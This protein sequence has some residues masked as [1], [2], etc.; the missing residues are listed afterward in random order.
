M[1]L[2][3][4]RNNDQ[5]NEV[6]GSRFSELE[7]TFHSIM[8]DVP[9]DIETM[10]TAFTFCFEMY[11]LLLLPIPERG[12]HRSI[13]LIVVVSQAGSLSSVDPKRVE[14]CLKQIS[15]TYEVVKNNLTKENAPPHIS[16]LLSLIQLCGELNDP[17]AAKLEIKVVRYLQRHTDAESGF[18]LLVVPET[19]MLF[20]QAV[21]DTVLQEE[22]RFAGPSSCFAKALE[23]KQPITLADIPVERRHEVEKIIRRQINTLLCVPVCVSDSKD[24]L[25]LA[26]MV[27]KSNNEQFTQQ[28]IDTILQCFKYTATVLTSTLAFQNERKLKNQTQ[29]LLLVARKLFTR[30]D[31]NL[32][33]SWNETANLNKVSS[34]EPDSG[35]SAGLSGSPRL[36]RCQGLGPTSGH[37]SEPGCIAQLINSLPTTQAQ[38][39][40][41]VLPLSAFRGSDQSSSVCRPES[42][43]VERA[44]ST[45]RH[46]RSD[47]ESSSEYSTASSSAPSSNQPLLNNDPNKKP[48]LDMKSDKSTDPTFCGEHNVSDHRSIADSSTCFYFKQKDDLAPDV[49]L[50]L[51]DQHEDMTMKELEFNRYFFN[52]LEQFKELLSAVDS[53]N[54]KYASPEFHVSPVLNTSPLANVSSMTSMSPDIMKDYFHCEDNVHLPDKQIHKID[55]Y[56]QCESCKLKPD[57]RSRTFRKFKSPDQTFFGQKQGVKSAL[58]SKRSNSISLQSCNIKMLSHTSLPPEKGSHC[59]T[60]IKNTL[61]KQCRSLSNNRNMVNRSSPKVDAGYCNKNRKPVCRL[62]RSVSNS[63]SRGVSLSPMERKKTSTVVEVSTDSVYQVVKPSAQCGIEDVS[64]EASFHSLSDEDTDLDNT[65]TSIQRLLTSIQD[66]SRNDLQCS[67]VLKVKKCSTEEKSDLFQ[68]DSDLGLQN[69]NDK[70][71]AEVQVGEKDEDSVC[72]LGVGKSCHSNEQGFAL[73]AENF[74]TDELVT[75]PDPCRTTQSSPLNQQ[76]S[77]A[78]L[79]GERDDE[80]VTYPDP[81]RTTHSS[82]L[83]VQAS[84]AQLTG[85]GDHLTSAVDRH[86]ELCTFGLAFGDSF[87]PVG[88][89]GKD[90]VLPVSSKQDSSEQ[91]LKVEDIVVV[92]NEETQFIQGSNNNDNNCDYFQDAFDCF[93][94]TKMDYSHCMKYIETDHF[95]SDLIA[96]EHVES[97]HVVSVARNTDEEVSIKIHLEDD[98]RAL[99]FHNNEFISDGELDYKDQSKSGEDANCVAGINAENFTCAS[100]VLESETNVKTHHWAYHLEQGVDS[101]APRDVIPSAIDLKHLSS[102][103]EPQFVE[104][105]SILWEGSLLSQ[106]DE[107]SMSV[108]GDVKDL[109]S[110]NGSEASNL[111]LDLDMCSVYLEETNYED[112][113]SSHVIRVPGDLQQTESIVTSSI[114]TDA[115][116][117]N[118][119]ISEYKKRFLEDNISLPSVET[120]CR[121]ELAFKKSDATTEIECDPSLKTETEENKDLSLRSHFLNINT[122]NVST[123]K[124]TDIRAEKPIKSGVIWS[125]EI[126]SEVEHCLVPD[127][128][129]MFNMNSDLTLHQDLSVKQTTGCIFDQECPNV[130]ANVVNLDSLDNIAVDDDFI[131]YPDMCSYEIHLKE[132]SD[133]LSSDM[134]LKEDSRNVHI[135]VASQDYSQQEESDQQVNEESDEQINEES[136]QEV[137]EK[138]DQQINEESHQQV[139][140]E[141]DQEVNE[142][143]FDQQVYKES[144][145]EVNEESDQEVNESYQNV[146]EESDQQVNEESDQQINEES[147]QEV[148]EE[149][150]DQQVNEK[151]DQEVNESYQNVN[152]E[153]DQEVNEKSDQQINEESHQQVNGESDQEVNEE[154][155]QEVNEESDQEVK[156]ESNQQINEEYDQQV[157]DER[158]FNKE[159]DQE[160]NEEFDQQVKEESDQEVNE[161]FVQEINEESDQEVNEESDQEVNEESDQQVNE[162]SDQEVN[163]ESDQQVNEE[164]NQEVNEKSDQQINEEFHQQVNGESDQEVNEESN[165]EVNEESDQ[166]VKEESDQQINEEYD[167]QINDEREFNKESDQEVNEEFDQEINEESDQD[168]NEE[169]DQEVNEES[170]QEVNEESDQE[171]NEESDQEVNEESDQQVNEESDQQ[172]NEE[173]DPQVIK[174]S[175]QQDNKESDQEINDE[176]D[177]KEELVQ[178]VKDEIEIKEE[179]VQEVNDEIEIN[180]VFDHECYDFSEEFKKINDESDQDVNDEIDFKDE[181]CQFNDEIDFNE[182][183]GQQVNDEIEFSEESDQKVNEEFDQEVTYETDF[184]KE[185]DQQL[186]NER[187]FK[188]H[189]HEK[190]LNIESNQEV[191]TKLDVQHECSLQIIFTTDFS[192]KLNLET[193]G[194]ICSLKKSNQQNVVAINTMRIT[195]QIK[196]NEESNQILDEINVKK[197]SSQILDDI[198]FNADSIQIQSK[199]DFNAELSQIQKESSQQIHNVKDFEDESNH[200]IQ[201]VKLSQQIHDEIDF[202]EIFVQYIHDEI[203]FNKEPG[204]QSHDDF[205]EEAGQQSQDD[206]NEEAGQQSQ[207]DFNE[208]PGQQ[209]H[210][211]FNEEPGQQSHDDFNEEPGQQSHDDFNEEPAQ[212]S[213]DDF[214]EEPGQQ[215]QDDFNEEAGQQSH[216]DFNEEPSQQSHDDFN[217]EAAQ[218]IHDDDLSLKIQEEKDICM[219]LSEQIYY[220]EDYIA[221]SGQQSHDETDLKEE[222]RP[223]NQNKINLFQKLNPQIIN[224]IASCD[225]LN[226]P[227]NDEID[228]TSESTQHKSYESGITQKYVESLSEDQQIITALNS[229]EESRE[230]MCPDLDW[231]QQCT[232]SSDTLT[233]IQETIEQVTTEVNVHSQTIPSLPNKTNALFIQDT[234]GIIKEFGLIKLRQPMEEKTT[235]GEEHHLITAMNF[236]N[237][238]LNEEHNKCNDTNDITADNQQNILYKIELKKMNEQVLEEDICTEIS[239]RDILKVSCDETSSHYTDEVFI[240]AFSQLI[241]DEIVEVSSQQSDHDVS[242]QQSDNEIDPED[243]IISSLGQ[244][245]G[246]LINILHLEPLSDQMGVCEYD[247]DVVCLDSTQCLPTDLEIKYDEGSISFLLETADELE[248]TELLSYPTR[249]QDTTFH[250]EMGGQMYE[251]EEEKLYQLAQEILGESPEQEEILLEKTADLNYCCLDYANQEPVVRRQDVYLTKDLFLTDSS[252]EVIFHTDPAIETKCGSSFDQAN[253]HLK[254]ADISNRESDLHCEAHLL[255]EHYVKLAHCATCYHLT[256]TDKE[257]FEPFETSTTDSSID[258]VTGL[259]HVSLGTIADA[260]SPKRPLT[261]SYSDH[262]IAIG[263]FNSQSFPLLDD[264]SMSLPDISICSHFDWSQNSNRPMTRF[265]DATDMRSWSSVPSVH[266]KMSPFDS[267]LRKTKSDQNLKLWSPRYSWSPSTQNSFYVHP[268]PWH[269]HQ[270]ANDLSPLCISSSGTLNTSSSSLGQNI[271]ATAQRILKEDEEIRSDSSTK[272]NIAAGYS[273]HLKD[274][275]TYGEFSRDLSHLKSKY[276]S[277]FKSMPRNDMEDLSLKT[278]SNTKRIVKAIRNNLHSSYAR[279]SDILKTLY[280]PET[281]SFQDPNSQPDFK[282]NWKSSGDNER[283]AFR[284]HSKK[285]TDDFSEL[286][287]VYTRNNLEHGQGFNEHSGQPVGFSSQSCLVGQESELMSTSRKRYISDYSHRTWNESDLN[288][289]AD[290]TDFLD[291]KKP[292]PFDHT[293]YY[294]NK[295]HG[296]NTYMTFSCPKDETYGRLIFHQHNHGDESQIPSHSHFQ[297]SFMDYLNADSRQHCVSFLNEKTNFD[298]STESGLDSSMTDSLFDGTLDKGSDDSYE[299]H[300]LSS[301]FAGARGKENNNHYDE[302]IL[303]SSLAEEV[304]SRDDMEDTFNECM[305]MNNKEMED[306]GFVTPAFTNRGINAILAEDTSEGSDSGESDPMENNVYPDTDAPNVCLRKTLAKQTGQKDVK[307]SDVQRG[308]V[309]REN[310]D[311]LTLGHLD[312]NLAGGP[313]NLNINVVLQN[314]IGNSED[315]DNI[316]IEGL[317]S[318]LQDYQSRGPML[319]PVLEVLDDDPASRTDELNSDCSPGEDTQVSEHVHENCVLKEDKMED[320]PDISKYK[321]QNESSEENSED[322]ITLETDKITKVVYKSKTEELKKEGLGDGIAHMSVGPKSL[323]LSDA[324]EDV[325]VSAGDNAAVSRLV[326]ALKQL[327]SSALQ[328]I[329]PD[330]SKPDHQFVSLMNKEMLQMFTLHDTP[331]NSPPSGRSYLND[332]K[333]HNESCSS[334]DTLSLR[335][336]LAEDQQEKYVHTCASQSLLNKSEFQGDQNQIPEIINSDKRTTLVTGVLKPLNCSYNLVNDSTHDTFISQTPL[337]PR[338]YRDTIINRSVSTDV[339]GNGSLGSNLFTNSSK[340]LDI[341]SEGMRREGTSFFSKI[342]GDYSRDTQQQNA[343]TKGI[344]TQEALRSDK[345]LTSDS[346]AQDVPVDNFDVID[347]SLKPRISCPQLISKDSQKSL[348]CHFSD[349]NVQKLK[350]QDELVISRPQNLLTSVSQNREDNFPILNSVWPKL[351]KTQSLQSNNY[352]L[353]SFTMNSPNRSTEL[354]Y[355]RDLGSRCRSHGALP[356]ISEA[357]EIFNSNSLT[358]KDFIMEHQ[359]SDIDSS[360]THGAFPQEMSLCNT[361]TPYNASQQIHNSIIG[362]KDACSGQKDE[363]SISFQEFQAKTFN[364]QPFGLVNAITSKHACTSANISDTTREIHTQSDVDTILNAVTKEKT[365]SNDDVF[366]KVEEET[367]HEKSGKESTGQLG[368]NGDNNQIRR[369]VTIQERHVFEKLKV[370]STS[371]SDIKIVRDLEDDKEARLTKQIWKAADVSGDVGDR[372]F[373]DQSKREN[374]MWASRDQS[375]ALINGHGVYKI[376][377]SNGDGCIKSDDCHAIKSVVPLTYDIDHMKTLK[378]DSHGR[379]EY[380]ETSSLPIA[381][382]V[383]ADETVTMENKAVGSSVQTQEKCVETDNCI[384]NEQWSNA[385]MDPLFKSPYLESTTLN[386]KQNDLLK[387]FCKTDVCLKEIKLVLLNKDMV[388]AQV[389]SNGKTDQS[390]LGLKHLT[391]KLSSVPIIVTKDDVNLNEENIELQKNRFKSPIPNSS[392]FSVQ[393]NK[394]L[395]PVQD[396]HTKELFA[397]LEADEQSFKSVCEMIGNKRD[398]SNDTKQIQDPHHS[399]ALED[400]Q[401]STPLMDKLASPLLVDFLSCSSE[402]CD[403]EWQSTFSQSG[404][405]K[406]YDTFPKVISFDH[407]KSSS[408]SSFPDITDFDESNL[409]SDEDTRDADVSSLDTT[410]IAPSYS[411]KY[412]LSQPIKYQSLFRKRHGSNQTKSDLLFHKDNPEVSLFAPNLNLVQEEII[413]NQKDNVDSCA[414]DV[415][416]LSDFA[417][418]AAPI[419]CFPTIPFSVAPIT[420]RFPSFFKTQSCQDKKNTTEKQSVFKQRGCQQER[421]NS[422]I[423]ADKSGKHKARASDLAGQLYSPRVSPKKHLITEGEATPGSVLLDS[424]Y[425]KPVQ[426]NHWLAFKSPPSFRPSPT[427]KFKTKAKVHED[428]KFHRRKKL[429][430][431]LESVAEEKRLFPLPSFYKEINNANS[432]DLIFDWHQEL[433]HNDQIEDV[434]GFDRTVQVQDSCETC[435]YNSPE[436]I[437]V[438]SNQSKRSVSFQLPSEYS[439]CIIDTNYTS[440][441]QVTSVDQDLD[442]KPNVT[443]VEIDYEPFLFRYRKPGLPVITEEVEDAE[444]DL[445]SDSSPDIS[446]TSTSSSEAFTEEAQKEETCT[447]TRKEICTTKCSQEEETRDQHRRHAR[448]FPEL[449]FFNSRSSEEEATV[450]SKAEV[451]DLVARNSDRKLPDLSFFA[452]QTCSNGDFL[453]SNCLNSDHVLCQMNVSDTE[454]HL[455]INVEFTSDSINSEES[456]DQMTVSLQQD[457]GSVDT[458]NV[459]TTTESNDK[460]LDISKE[461]ILSELGPGKEDFSQVKLCTENSISNNRTS[462]ESKEYA[463]PLQCLIDKT[464]A[465]DNKECHVSHKYNLPL[466]NIKTDE[467]FVDS[468]DDAATLLRHLKEMDLTLETDS[469]LSFT[470][471]FDSPTKSTYHIDV[472]CVVHVEDC[473]SEASSSS[474]LI[475][476]SGHEI[477]ISAEWKTDSEEPSETDNAIVKNIVSPLGADDLNQAFNAGT[478]SDQKDD[479]IDSQ[480]NITYV[481]DESNESPESTSHKNDAC[482]DLEDDMNASSEAY[483]DNMERLGSSDEHLGDDSGDSPSDSDILLHTSSI[484]KDPMVLKRLTS[485]PPV[486]QKPA[487]EDRS[488]YSLQDSSLVVPTLSSDSFSTYCSHQSHL[489]DELELAAFLS[490]DCAESQDNKRCHLDCSDIA[491]DDRLVS[492][493]SVRKEE[494][495][496][497]LT[498]ESDGIVNKSSNSEDADPEEEKLEEGF[499]IHSEGLDSTESLTQWTDQ[500]SPH[501][502][503]LCY[504]H[505]YFDQTGA[506]ADTSNENSILDVHVSETSG[507][508]VEKLS[509]DGLCQMEILHHVSEPLDPNVLDT[510]DSKVEDENAMV[511]SSKLQSENLCDFNINLAPRSLVSHSL[512]DQT[513]ESSSQSGL[514][515]QS[516][517]CQLDDLF[518]ISSLSDPDMTVTEE[519]HH[520]GPDTCNLSFSFSN[521]MF[522][523]CQGGEKKRYSSF[524]SLSP[525]PCLR[526]SKSDHSVDSKSLCQNWIL[527]NNSFHDTQHLMFPEDKRT[528]GRNTVSDI[529]DFRRSAHKGPEYQYEEMTSFSAGW[530]SNCLLVGE[531]KSGDKVEDLNQCVLFEEDSKVMVTQESGTTEDISCSCHPV[532]SKFS[533]A[534]LVQHLMA[535]DQLENFGFCDDD[536]TKLLRE[537]MQEARNLTDAERCSVFLLDKDTDELV[538]MVFD[539]ITADDKEWQYGDG[540]QGEIRLPKTQGIAGHVATTGTLL[541]IRDAYSHP[542]FYRGIDDST[543]FRTRN[544]L[545]FP[546]KDEEG[547]VLGV[548]QLCNKKT[549][550]YFTTFDED[551]ASAFAVYCCISISHSLMY[552]KVIDI[553]YRNSLANELMMFH[554][555]SLMYKKLVDI[556]HRH[557]LANELMI[558]HI[559]QQVPM[560]EVQMMAENPI[561]PVTTFSINFDSFDFAPRTIPES[562]TV[563]SCI[564]MFEDLGFLAR[565]RIKI[566]TLVRFLLMVKKGYR[567]PPYHN[568][569]HAYAVTHFCYLL[570]KNLHLHNYLD[571][572]ELLALFVSCLCHDIDHRGTTNSFQ[573]QSQSVLAAL[574]SSEGSVMERH[575]LAQSMCILNTD[576]SNLFENLSS[577]EYQT[578]LDLM[579]EIILA[580]DLAHHLRTVKEQEQLAE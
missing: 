476:S 166:E 464:S 79:T 391:Q 149:F 28:D 267:Q 346:R 274:S 308:Y 12:T 529:S 146:N 378:S 419:K 347:K 113:A 256:D 524:I 447:R 271:S 436:A 461:A 205:N 200:Y 24:L 445:N 499:L 62:C 350:Q 366:V 143:F 382:L 103:S 489:V 336:S 61:S 1:N 148:N 132:D 338:G 20:C 99:R 453:E 100:R 258:E 360:R 444:T 507:L 577:K 145:Q 9:S 214:N 52:N 246:P 472:S 239:Y 294:K 156:E 87:E 576:G 410:L 406:F 13:G 25:A 478:T 575:H 44:H 565:W 539:G 373:F 392:Y 567:N 229:N 485:E 302:T 399:S 192:Q 403:S 179:L 423:L 481:L 484:I 101:S 15:V 85:E 96:C 386:I 509:Q 76:A 532:S 535:R 124:Q 121:A 430:S 351:N 226:F 5:S 168:V 198:N 324:K 325:C 203:G 74:T 300:F 517:L 345:H 511:D 170:D 330:G 235:E 363:L 508:G 58:Q 95:Q 414:A 2:E 134:S 370:T 456:R 105:L 425:S 215:S 341:L 177:I 448:Y 91:I 328:S 546:I 311:P 321:P 193:N 342:R 216:D 264:Q 353:N 494:D 4:C 337:S 462:H 521:P 238:E 18:L 482:D 420:D 309:D 384:T 488:V 131:F 75:Y 8:L 393:H 122:D 407:S 318:A 544:I 550:Q 278:E 147:D 213:H 441:S 144:D 53:D 49:G 269:E 125:Q 22:V 251:I 323:Q 16:N 40:L 362:S 331:V 312:C 503:R 398:S 501:G 51:R 396:Q 282:S 263:F 506:E 332:D 580:T 257:H 549:F 272:G 292:L 284:Y 50:R 93:Q 164:S 14:L 354:C 90:P 188:P 279:S 275:F 496:T 140:G 475:L 207:D 449:P 114:K 68:L 515:G 189:H 173:T 375:N 400:Q 574:Y 454:I 59:S 424:F 231:N 240:E 98:Q 212:Q 348:Y 277:G 434:A 545:C 306:H 169:S 500:V 223:K 232:P 380:T 435:E 29:A 415:E 167:Q 265:S 408:E 104:E 457:L 466:A 249:V 401:I 411:E 82:P 190:D 136:N 322:F 155:N 562:Q 110:L 372:V 97:S 89:L 268:K 473:D 191:E 359:V 182:D 480:L 572:I 112:V 442:L 433:A 530:S 55:N 219:K 130:S 537:I 67:L 548:A 513:S 568:W 543:G 236:N 243:I 118:S 7:S 138:S 486:K 365:T 54:V 349:G 39:T 128:I 522:C 261:I 335:R 560:E 527:Q 117:I 86:I 254:W 217:E 389:D 209:S 199:V 129:Q 60:R 283:G 151:S 528:G 26:C 266:K 73:L 165:Q 295:I 233:L 429:F 135:S 94:E 174:E 491:E 245:N 355:Q 387:L 218:P 467:T 559:N 471:Q 296:S 417:K 358:K 438:E 259:K 119:L 66:S 357:Y 181:V 376:G 316:N 30:L 293:K 519:L 250:Y 247:N 47:S 70:S 120:H 202:K 197:E 432:N 298:L 526:K 34:V 409:S 63:R 186:V 107:E 80:L 253:S 183:F 260:L 536:L 287:H 241:H 361:H 127:N 452:Q 426:A 270:Q 379:P 523:H 141:S 571:D 208:E 77:V 404:D 137:N 211:D 314:S 109:E 48:S 175:D 487:K 339:M 552:K 329:P 315:L 413:G 313:L 71:V 397:E 172:V 356:R 469:D 304:S 42:C 566:D 142:E 416:S 505:L 78:Q 83:T 334:E 273:R 290:D 21:G 502:S 402:S 171:V 180:K 555:K 569:M 162:E 150:F 38:N 561:L 570:I 579:R 556:Q 299:C 381:D 307:E 32:S 474:S 11:L 547:M 333:P 352:D 459:N 276:Q 288:L 27:N 153:S 285:I 463:Q 427:N 390:S 31:A 317:Q 210:D 102:G 65:D 319:S 187:E 184:N 458:N 504:Y 126:N 553:Q 520:E 221:D 115:W 41:I 497:E 206:F 159:S 64:D 108:T 460:E 540:V 551:I 418:V 19:Q 385:E 227:M 72:T 514:I 557:R 195:E 367:S 437:R 495:S 377:D 237:D 446:M 310:Q 88:C 281:T 364:L 498:A 81:C 289:T 157:N 479:D 558:F 35:H 305:L 554:M 297:S 326:E 440:D 541:N 383:P 510:R 45:V 516:D 443:P 154:C 196:L 477:S 111:N 340:S 421:Y 123:C 244:I 394:C 525:Y 578:V 220:K 248:K 163:E 374:N 490:D 431:P 178:E 533:L 412:R 242:K 493:S 57:I 291:F 225:T 228:F 201:D 492:D 301:R 139:N 343:F 465:D 161:E 158:E 69:T 222:L 224:K 33:Q 280:E 542:L 388:Q 56:T 36:I 371:K 369:E 43:L 468:E 160:V 286:D 563:M 234:Q 531:D 23:T 10:E 194:E 405:P 3:T 564:S 152:E 303:E 84:V 17:D 262:D 455:D 428:L 37:C 46:H 133:S 255:P 538:A 320:P 470:G 518:A 230:P 106:Q 327:H 116:E 204:Q 6:S 368:C 92:Q 252:R 451:V 439:F 176:I 422:F 185:F 395:E 534:D 344:L 483:S 512:R 573:V 450:D